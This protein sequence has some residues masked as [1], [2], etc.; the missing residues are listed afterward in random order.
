MPISEPEMQWRWFQW[1]IPPATCAMALFNWLWWFEGE[2]FRPLVALFVVFGLI[3]FAY[4]LGFK[5]VKLHQQRF[6]FFMLTF[7]VPLILGVLGA[8]GGF[9]FAGVV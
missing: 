2:P 1:F 9:L 8:F 6:V 7:I 5:F 4:E 3:A